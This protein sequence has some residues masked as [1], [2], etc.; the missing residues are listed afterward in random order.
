MPA[1]A[2]RT[3]ACEISLALALRRSGLID[4]ADNGSGEARPAVSAVR[5]ATHSTRE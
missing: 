3:A 5:T 2:H 1:Q 4:E